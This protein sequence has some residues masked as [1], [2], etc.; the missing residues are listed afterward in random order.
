MNE[1]EL[2]SLIRK[3]RNMEKGRGISE[4]DASYKRGFRSAL[5]LLVAELDA[6]KLYETGPL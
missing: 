4:L 5:Y 2:R 3:V 1:K 6:R